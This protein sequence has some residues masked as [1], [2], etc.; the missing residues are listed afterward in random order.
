MLTNALVYHTV[1]K[2]VKVFRA[3]YIDYMYV[4]TYFSHIDSCFTVE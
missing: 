2:E 4:S 1:L 3:G